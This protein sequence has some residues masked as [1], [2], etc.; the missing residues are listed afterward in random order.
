MNK[1]GQVTVFII[2]GILVVIGVVLFFIFSG[3]DAEKK[4]QMPAEMESV[5]S[6]VKEC[7]EESTIDSIYY[8][9]LSGGYYDAPNDSIDT[10]PYFLPVYFDGGVSKIP[11]KETMEKELSKSIEDEIIYCLDFEDFED[12]GYEISTPN[13]PE[14][15]SDILKGRTNVKMDYLM[16]IRKGNTSVQIESFEETVGFDYLGKYETVKEFIELQETDPEYI[17]MTQLEEMGEEKGFDSELIGAG[18]SSEFF[19][20]FEYPG[21]VNNNQTYMYSFAIRY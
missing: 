12:E 11:S 15:E 10:G 1:R 14:A 7:L 17:F 3:E 20:N 21:E 16:N 4:E 18:N 5:N 19:Y 8:N 6:F 13:Q 2:I 9:S